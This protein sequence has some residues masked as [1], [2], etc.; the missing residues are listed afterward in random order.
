[1]DNL[2]VSE[3]AK[4]LNITSKE[5]IEKFAEISI[6]VKSHSNVVTPEQIRKIKEH[7]GVAPKKSGAKKAFI[8]KKRNRL[9]MLKL[10]K[11]NQNLLQK[12]NVSKGFKE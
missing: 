7:L 4:E 11:R 12:W 1:M 2:R 6:T 10:L 9:K 8:V 5:L 3:L